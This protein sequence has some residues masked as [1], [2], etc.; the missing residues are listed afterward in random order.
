M[1]S[2]STS[3]LLIVG[4]GST[5]NPDSSAPTLTHAAEIRLRGI[6]AEVACCFWKEEPSLRDALLF[7]R[8]ETIREVY[9]VPNFISEGYFTR[10]VIPRELELTGPET[11]RSGGRIWKYCEPVGNHP[12]MT[13]L[14]LQRAHEAAPEI[15][16]TETSLLIVGHG[17]GLND[18]SALAAKH[19]VEKIRTLNRYAAVLNV[20]MEEPPLV[21]DWLTLTETRNVV[22]VPFFISDGLHSYE[23]IPVML[24][25]AGADTRLLGEGRKSANPHQVRGRSLFYSTAIGTD[26][27]FAEIIMEQA[28]GFEGRKA[29]LQSAS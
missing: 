11:E 8:D 3:A 1:V 19:Q 21:S 2:S 25:I 13:E 16:K 14:L 23:D 24:G 26:P 5:V 29:E 18:N 27:K 28:Q 12:R 9:V 4:H 22:V 17:T 20:Y 10:T 6:F 7:F 15:R